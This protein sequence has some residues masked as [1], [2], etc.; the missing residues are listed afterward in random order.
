MC[1]CSG[2]AFSW[3]EKMKY[4]QCCPAMRLICWYSGI[5]FSICERFRNVQCRPASGLIFDAQESRIQVAKAQIWA[6]PSWK[7]FDLLILRNRVLRFG[8]VHIRVVPP[9]YVCDLLMFRNSVLNM[10]NVQK[11]CCAEL[12]SGSI[13]ALSVVVFSGCENFK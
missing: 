1:W 3:C 12:Q 8:M 9:F 6:L 10:K 2:I 13:C 4:G 11:R 7:D 5:A